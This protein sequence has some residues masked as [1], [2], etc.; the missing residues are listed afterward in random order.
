MGPEVVHGLPL[1][2]DDEGVRP[3]L[4]ERAAI[5]VDR[6][7]VLD[8]ALLGM[9]RRH[10]GL[11]VP[12]DLVPLAGLGGDDGDDVDH[13]FLLLNSVIPSAARDLYGPQ[14]SLAALGM[15]ILPYPARP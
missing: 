15:T 14:R 2:D 4:G 6:G 1:L 5:G 13:G 8:A 3:E 9:H 10:I 12:E 7:A 11:E